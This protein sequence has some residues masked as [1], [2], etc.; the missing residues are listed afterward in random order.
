M[1]FILPLLL[2]LNIAQVFKY[3]GVNKRPNRSQ[4]VQRSA[5]M[6]EV[7]RASGGMEMFGEQGHWKAALVMLNARLGNGFIVWRGGRGK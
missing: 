3:R 7:L 5:V 4:T 1:L 2:F 6:S